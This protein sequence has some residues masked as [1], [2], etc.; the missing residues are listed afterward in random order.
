VAE[1]DSVHRLTRRLDARL[2]G[3]VIVDVDAR[4]SKVDPGALSGLTF[5]KIVPRGKHILMRLDGAR[6]VTLHSHLKIS[7]R[8][9]IIGKD[10]YLPRKMQES[11]RLS[12]ALEDGRTLAALD[13]PIL[14]MVP[15]AH[16]EDLVGYLGPDILADDFDIDAAVQRM[17]S[18]P[19][20]P[21]VQAILDQ[22]NVCGIGNVWAVE[23]L[24]LR[25]LHPWRTV[26]S[27]E[28]E[29]LLALNRKMM[30]YSRDVHKGM[31]TTGNK[32][33]GETHWVY[34]QKDRPCRRC[35]TRIELRHGGS[36]PYD[37]ET[38]WCPHCQP[39]RVLP[40]E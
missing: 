19:Q 38:W 35:G 24:F 12:L 34:G 16:E 22:R 1:G 18:E 32:R 39:E 15:T 10:R 9:V 33:R 5:R 26:E 21:V 31:I 17:A 30:T 23:S 3:A 25:G 40:A 8:W 13:M 2:A 14:E 27:V 28:L 7:G 4:T 6:S 37:R 11:L 20:R 29:P 36:G